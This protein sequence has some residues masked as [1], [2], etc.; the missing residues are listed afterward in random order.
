MRNCQ[1]LHLVITYHDPVYNLQPLV[2][3]ESIVDGGYR[4][5]PHEQH[6]PKIVELVPNDV[7]ARAVIVD[8]MESSEASAC[9]R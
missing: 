9:P 1:T 5:A 3:E 6:Y 7:D 2:V 8:D 4:C